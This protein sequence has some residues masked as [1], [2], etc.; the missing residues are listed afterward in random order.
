MGNFSDRSSEEENV[1]R[2]L[3]LMES[4]EI[5]L[6]IEWRKTVQCDALSGEER[7]VK[8]KRRVRFRR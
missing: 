4:K 2:W 5:L 7:V 8:V 6:V 3:A 1:M